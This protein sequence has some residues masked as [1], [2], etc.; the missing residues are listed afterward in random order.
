MSV[1]LLSIR[2]LRRGALGVCAALLAAGGAS[3]QPAS[4]P[5]PRLADHIVAVVNQE[6][7]TNAEVQQRVAAA[8]AE[9]AR[10][11]ARLPS[12]DQLRRQVLESMIDERAQLTHARDSG[13]H[14]EDPELDRAVANVAQQNRLTLPQLRE[15]LQR[16]GIDFQRFR[17]NIRDQILLER[18]REREVQSR[19]KISD[20]EI[21]TLLAGRAS[22]VAPP[23]YN[24]AQ[25]LVSVP[26]AAGEAEVAERRAIAEKALARAKSGDDFA[27]LVGELSDGAKDN[28]GALGLRSADRLPDLFVVAVTPLRAGDVAPQLVKSGAGFHVL[29]L[30]ERRDGGLMVTQTHARHI[31]L[32]TSEQL[33]QPAAIARLAE[34]KQ[35]IVNGQASFTQLARDNSEDGSAAQGGELGWASPGQFVPEFE[36]AMRRLEPMQVSDP[37]VSRFGV[38]LIQ[39]V[40][41]RQQP[42]DRKQQRDIARNVLRERKFDT[43]Y[44]EWS[45]EVRARAYVEMREPPP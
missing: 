19:I 8:R 7:V 20:G 12:D 45:R 1:A 18:V 41:R 21:D 13:L 23:D 5:P 35:Q 22:G 17:S 24:V 44:K 37:I 33:P 40:E 15:R 9:A 36:E 34:M 43:A 30:L 16:E 4:A 39:V 31:L 38:H 29:K 11:G 25:L 42:V 14:V 6:L 27:K 10:A 2:L 26:E 3:A 32:R 28:G